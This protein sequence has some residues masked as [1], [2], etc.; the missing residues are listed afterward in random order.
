MPDSVSFDLKQLIRV[1]LNDSDL[2]AEI[3]SALA[4]GPLP[5]R[6]PVVNVSDGEQTYQSML[7]TNRDKSPSDAGFIVRDSL[8][9]VAGRLTEI[10]K[11]DHDASTISA[12]H[13]AEKLGLTVDKLK[14]RST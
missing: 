3:E 14:G 4:E 1:C 2:K 10:I 8:G 6:T 12:E 7:K 5:V 9:W 11:T 13:M